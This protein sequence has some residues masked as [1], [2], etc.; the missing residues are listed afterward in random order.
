MDTELDNAP[1]LI[2]NL[3]DLRD[4]QKFTI[5]GKGYKSHITS[6]NQRGEAGIVR[7]SM[8]EGEDYKSHVA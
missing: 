4:S 6:L 3:N 1:S 5:E 8:M 7:E 2:S